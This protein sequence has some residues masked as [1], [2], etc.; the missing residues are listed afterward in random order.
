[1]EKDKDKI[2]EVM[3]YSNRK[4]GL[5]FK[6]LD[7]WLNTS[8]DINETVYNNAKKTLINM[9]LCCCLL[10]ECD[11]EDFNIFYSPDFHIDIKGHVVI[12]VH[13][14]R[15]LVNIEIAETKIGFFTEYEDGINTTCYDGIETDFYSIPPALYPHI[16]N[17]SVTGL[18]RRCETNLDDLLRQFRILSDFAE[19]KSEEVSDELENLLDDNYSVLNELHQKIEKI[20][21][22]END[23]EREKLDDC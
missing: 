11:A 2:Y 12:N 20:I 1:M 23:V 19:Y 13:P 7:Y 4:L 5:H 6:M 15:G 22:E 18:L 17:D 16:I 9:Q 21:K 14:T 8:H 3:S 10:P